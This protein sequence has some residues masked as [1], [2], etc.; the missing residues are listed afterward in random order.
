MLIHALG[1]CFGH[2][3]PPKS[4]WVIHC[5][6]TNH[7]QT[8]QLTGSGAWEQLSRCFS[9]VLGSVAMLTAAGIIWTLCGVRETTFKLVHPPMLHGRSVSCYSVKYL[10]SSKNPLLPTQISWSQFGKPHPQGGKE[11]QR[12]QLA[13]VGAIHTSSSAESCWQ[14]LA[15]VKPRCCT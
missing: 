4:V 3:P 6:L 7:S 1:F 13:E 10:K 14:L 8:F 12:S 9:S 11:I 2:I 5:H 15:V